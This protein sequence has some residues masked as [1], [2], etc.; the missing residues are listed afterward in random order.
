MRR[1]AVTGGTGLVGS[2]VARE[3]LARGDAAVLVARHPG[4]SLSRDQRIGVVSAPIDDEHAL[5]AAFDGCDAVIH[6]AGINRERGT[7]TYERVHVHGT[8]AVVGAAQRAG[9]RHIALVSF[10]RARPACGSAYHESKW[11]AE[12]IV[13]DS[14]LSY[15][16]VKPG[17]IFG[18]GDHMLDHLSRAFHTFPIFGLVGVASTR[19][20][21]PVAVEDV[22]RILAAA[23]TDPR[24]KDRT[25]PVLGPEELRLATAVRRVAAITGCHPLFVPMPVTAHRVLAWCFE[26]TMTVPLVSAAQVR[27]LSEGLVEPVLAPDALPDDLEPRTPFSHDAIRARLP[28]PDRFHRSDLLCCHVEPPRVSWRLVGLSRR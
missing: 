7:Q 8:R 12:E 20:L 22:A 24:L 21:R 19:R 13:R 2:H 18:R 9:V 28:A 3:L 14:G 6:C 15:T 26:R 17:V 1:V 16:I 11:S 27:I 5:R 23:A 4:T 25:V 10:L